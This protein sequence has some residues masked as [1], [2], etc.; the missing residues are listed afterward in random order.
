MGSGGEHVELITVHRATNVRHSCAGNFASH[1]QLN[2]IIAR[3]RTSTN[4]PPLRPR[5]LLR[6]EAGA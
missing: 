1:H 2:H 6:L 4:T 3:V 5:V